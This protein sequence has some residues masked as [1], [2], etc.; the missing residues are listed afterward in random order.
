M[1]NT[2]QDSGFLR[3]LAAEALL[4]AAEY[5]DP[6][7]SMSRQPVIVQLMRLYHDFMR[8]ADALEATATATATEEDAMAA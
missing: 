2:E 6:L 4:A 3:G 1:C 5:L 7:L 8:R